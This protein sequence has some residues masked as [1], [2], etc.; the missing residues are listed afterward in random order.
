MY[1]QSQKIEY[2]SSC[3]L[4]VKRLQSQIIQKVLGATI[5]KPLVA[6][7]GES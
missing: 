3:T 2:P 1:A 7:R 6:E 4:K 5:Q